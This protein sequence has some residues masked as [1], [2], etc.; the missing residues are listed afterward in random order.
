MLDRMLITIT[1]SRRRLPGGRPFHLMLLSLAT[2]AL[3]DWL[4]NVALLA[5]VFGRTGSATWVALTTA[6]RVLPIVVLGPVGGVLADRYDR[7]A[8]MIGADAARMVLMVALALV[9][10]AG[11]PLVLAPL[12]AAL[13]TAASTVTSP[14]VA[15]ST[16]RLVQDHELQRANALRAGIGQGAI[17]A[18]PALGAVVLAL[19]DPAVAI[20]LNGLS[21]AISAAAVMAIGPG[22]AFRPKA[23]QAAGAPSL[24]GDVKAG[25]HALR[26]APT[27][28]RLVAADVLCSAVYG[29]LTVMLVLVSRRVGAGDGGYGI[30]LCGFGAGGLIGA[31]VLARADAPGAWRRTLAVALLLVAVAMAALGQSSTLVEAVVL[32]VL[33][34]GGMVVGEVLSDTA[35]PRMLDDEVLGRAYGLALPVSLSGIVIG[36]LA[37][38]PLVSLLGLQGAF[39]AAGVF[40]ALTAGLLLRRPLAL[41]PAAAPVAP[42][43]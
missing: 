8:L 23:R 40:V 18:G 10:A 38:G 26:G 1:S 27:A 4:Y 39:A 16:P 24:L 36:S 30:L 9:A 29:L 2:S 25:A 21:F 3:G 31:T 41:V 12:L 28:V 14:S 6:G 15:A 43:H 35:L 34:G 19:T 7:R 37:A 22:P 42:A 13:A 32:A 17:V 5:L 11:L 33:G 20:L